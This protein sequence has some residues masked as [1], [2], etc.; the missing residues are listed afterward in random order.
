MYT[1]RIIVVRDHVSVLT[2]YLHLFPL[3]ATA[4]V[5][6]HP[7]AFETMSADPI[8]GSYKMETSENFDDF[9]KAISKL[10]SNRLIHMVM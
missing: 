1:A 5:N 8:V 3:S 9:L 4:E 10:H 7:I 6:T 2:I